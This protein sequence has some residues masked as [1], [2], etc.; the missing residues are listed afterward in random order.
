MR[1]DTFYDLTSSEAEYTVAITANTN[2]GEKIV[3][4][5]KRSFPLLYSIFRLSKTTCTSQVIVVV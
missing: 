5:A 1:A 4:P 3:S 2:V